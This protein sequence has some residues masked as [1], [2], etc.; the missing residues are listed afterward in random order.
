MVFKDNVNT[1]GS[2]FL[3]KCTSPRFR[4]IL[5]LILIIYISVTSIGISEA[6]SSRSFGD[7]ANYG[8]VL[9]IRADLRLLNSKLDRIYRVLR[10][11]KTRTEQKQEQREVKKFKSLINDK[12]D[13]TIES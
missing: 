6:C 10:I 11:E 12:I 13:R 3:N 2:I 9:D 7:D 5:L 8:D 4:Y 1:K